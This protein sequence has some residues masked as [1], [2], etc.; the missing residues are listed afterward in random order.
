MSSPAQGGPSVP[1]E[2]EKKNVGKAIL[3][4]VKTVWRKAD[5]RMSFSGKPGQSSS[6][7]AEGAVVA[8]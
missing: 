5:K 8:R 7:A 3:S 6:A 2:K 4:R 1:K